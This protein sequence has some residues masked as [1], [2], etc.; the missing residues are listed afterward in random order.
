[1]FEFTIVDFHK[2]GVIL[3]GRKAIDGQDST[4]LGQ[5]FY[6]KHSRHYRVSGKM[7]CKKRL[8]EGDILDAHNMGITQFN[9]LVNQQKWVPVRKYFFNLGGI[10]NGL[11]VG[12]INRHIFHMLVFFDVLLDQFGKLN[13]GEMSWPV[14]NDMR[15]DGKTYQRQI[16]DYIQ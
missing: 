13:I 14:G 8:V 1:M 11:L 4:C 12:V 5:G 15:L 10:V 6:L 2:I 16:P 7:P 3:T 9:D